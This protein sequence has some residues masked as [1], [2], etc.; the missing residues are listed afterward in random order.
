VKKQV[1]KFINIAA[2]NN[3]RFHR[4]VHMM[5]VNVRITS[6]KT[7]GC[8]SLYTLKLKVLTMNQNFSRYGQICTDESAQILQ[9][10]NR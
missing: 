7:S 6:A 5:N 1:S 2:Y 10:K 4:C 3:A 9:T 8:V